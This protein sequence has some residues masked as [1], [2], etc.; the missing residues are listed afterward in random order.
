MKLH[1][2]IGKPLAESREA[3]SEFLASEL[4]RA[5]PSG[6][7]LRHSDSDSLS[8]ALE[9]CGDAPGQAPVEEYRIWVTQDLKFVIF[10]HSNSDAGPFDLQSALEQSLV[11]DAGVLRFFGVSAAIE[12]LMAHYQPNRLGL[13]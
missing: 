5:V 13:T 10:S 11:I 1:E 4:K 7:I 12:H 6:W 2:I 3:A 9:A 8:W